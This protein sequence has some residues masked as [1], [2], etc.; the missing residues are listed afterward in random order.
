MSG[1]H[2]PRARAQAELFSK[3]RAQAQERV[4]FFFAMSASA[5]ATIFDERYDILCQK[6]YKPWIF[7]SGKNKVQ[8]GTDIFWWQIGSE[9]YDFLSHLWNLADIILC[10]CCLKFVNLFSNWFLLC[11]KTEILE[12]VMSYRYKLLIDF[13]ILNL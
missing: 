12:A 7:H 5:S 10:H 6:L 9:S 1:T 13:T 8:T 11:S 4:G 2:E 3:W